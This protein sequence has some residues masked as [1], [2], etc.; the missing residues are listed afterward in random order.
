MIDIINKMSEMHNGY[1]ILDIA[2]R[3]SLEKYKE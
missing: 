2:L 1:D 3:E